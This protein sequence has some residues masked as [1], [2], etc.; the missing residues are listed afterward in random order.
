MLIEKV[1]E[2]PYTH[3]INSGYMANSMPHFKLVYFMLSN[4]KFISLHIEYI[5]ESIFNHSKYIQSLS[6]VLI[7]KNRLL[8]RKKSE[9]REFRIELLHCEKNNVT[10]SNSQWQFQ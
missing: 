7:E 5:F 10:C 8:S 4:V 9:K 3:F 1:Q 2:A 6:R